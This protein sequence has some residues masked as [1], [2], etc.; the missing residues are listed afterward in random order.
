VLTD[1]S[2]VFFGTCALVLV[3]SVILLTAALRLGVPATLAYFSRPL[4][5]AAATRN[6]IAC[7]PVAVETMTVELNASPKACE[8]YIPVSFARLRFGTILHFAAATVFT[9]A[10][11]GHHFGAGDILII[12]VLSVA[13]SFATLGVNGAA[14]LAPLAAVLRP[15]GL[16]Y[17]LVFPLL[18]I[19][20]PLALMVRIM[21]NV[22]VNCLIPAL[23][24]RSRVPEAVQA[25]PAE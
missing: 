18:I 25:A 22:A 16:P 9:G 15:F 19:I 2:Y 12:A 20:D 10:L 8:M 1:F 11:L 21:V 23:A 6:T 7:I 4:M 13:A 24:V 5:V 3:V 14:A 17:E